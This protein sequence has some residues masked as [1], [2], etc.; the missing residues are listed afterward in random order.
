MVKQVNADSFRAELRVT[1]ASGSGMTIQVT[2]NA[3]ETYKLQYSNNLKTWKAVPDLQS[4]QADF[5]GKADIKRM[6]KAGS[7]QIFYRLLNE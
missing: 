2:E 6:I 3:F 7:V 4:I 5:R 1:E